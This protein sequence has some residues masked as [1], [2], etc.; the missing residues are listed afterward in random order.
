MNK[1]GILDICYFLPNN[2]ETNEFLVSDMKLSWSADDI[3]AKTGIK[4]RHIAKEAECASDLG[5]LAA[6]KL[7]A[8]HENLRDKIDFLLFCSQSPD[9]ALPTTVSLLQKRLG[10][11]KD[12]GSLD[13]NQGCSGYIYGLAL[14]KG[15]IESAVASNVL[16]ITAETYSK[17][18]AKYDKQTRT[19]FGDGAAA[20][21]IQAEKCDAERLHSFAFGSDGRGKCNLIVPNSGARREVRNDNHL[22]MDGPEIFQFTLSVVPKT[23]RRILAQA[24]LKLED[25][26]Y[27]IFHQA[28]AFMLKH[29]RN[30]L[31]ISEDKFFIDLE[32]TG[33]TVSASIPIALCRAR[34]NGMVHSGMKVMLLGFGV[35]YSWGGCIVSI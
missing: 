9:Y 4:Q 21:L 2:I 28:N 27:F 15:L 20:T 19:I 32:D 31:K 29:L 14:A 34:K 10:L 5:V 1:A 22:F 23:V 18:I 16:L 35:G 25:I 3:F 8:L 30:K 6:E 26:D 13:I 24:D 11:S 17:Y 12:C 33:N 7:F